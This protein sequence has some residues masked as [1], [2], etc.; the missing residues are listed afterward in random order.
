MNNNYSPTI[1]EFISGQERVWRR[2]VQALES[3]LKRVISLLT[4]S[5]EK[6]WIPF[7]VAVFPASQSDEFTKTVGIL[8]RRHRPLSPMK[9]KGSPS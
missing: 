6:N 1:T 2:I 5:I 3:T 7:C 9:I 8:S 4:L